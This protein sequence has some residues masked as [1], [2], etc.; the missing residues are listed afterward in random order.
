LLDTVYFIRCRRFPI[1]ATMSD[2]LP[3]NF[4]RTSM[5]GVRR[6]TVNSA[7]TVRTR[8]TRSTGYLPV[9]GVWF[10][11]ATSGTAVDYSSCFYAQVPPSTQ[12]VLRAGYQSS[13]APQ[14][15]TEAHFL[16]LKCRVDSCIL[17]TGMLL[18]INCRGNRYMLTGGVSA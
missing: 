2:L 3:T 5:A 1:V 6:R 13:T 10:P 16:G 14:T 9:G 18:C 17:N 8:T 12:S 11:G 4:V 7:S 15:N